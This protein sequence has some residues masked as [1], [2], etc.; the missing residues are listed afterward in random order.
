MKAKIIRG[1]IIGK[2]KGI[3]RWES[4]GCRVLRRDHKGQENLDNVAES[5][6][7]GPIL[8]SRCQCAPL[9]VSMFF[10]FSKYSQIFFFLG[11]NFHFVKYKIIINSI[12]NSKKGPFFPSRHSPDEDA[13]LFN[14]KRRPF[15]TV[16]RNGTPLT[17]SGPLFCVCLSH[18][19]VMPLCWTTSHPTLFFGS[20]VGWS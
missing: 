8:L 5:H 7:D 6:G 19:L 13:P 2:K 11:F 4:E 17:P 12:N 15:Y 9:L 18:N 1:L 16:T 3:L 14:I 10:Y 20:H